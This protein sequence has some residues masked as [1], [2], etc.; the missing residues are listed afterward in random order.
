MNVSDRG[1]KFFCI[2]LQCCHN[3]Y[4]ESKFHKGLQT[5]PARV[6]GNVVSYAGE[7]HAKHASVAGLASEGS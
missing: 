6:V 1:D 5:E 3:E 4:C 7:Y 2:A